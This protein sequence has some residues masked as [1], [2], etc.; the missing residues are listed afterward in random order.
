M[1][2]RP[3]GSQWHEATS[4]LRTRRYSPYNGKRRTHD[5][6]R[7]VI[8]RGSVLRFTLPRPLTGEEQN[9]LSW[10]GLYNEAGLGRLAVNPAMLAGVHPAFEEGTTPAGA[11]ETTAP[12]EPASAL[13]DLLKRRAN[14]AST[15][16]I[17]ATL[18]K[19]LE[20]AFNNALLRARHFHTLQTGEPLDDAPG[21]SQ[22]GQIRELANQNRSNPAKLYGALFEGE[23]ALIRQ[24]SGWQLLLAPDQRLCDEIPDWMITDPAASNA[25][26]ADKN[27][28]SLK[29]LKTHP[30]LPD[31]IGQ[32]ATR[33]LEG[34][35]GQI[36]AGTDTR[37]EE[38]THD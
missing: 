19:D 15:R 1:F 36:I 31:I 13:I 2:N 38:L 9:N 28:V 7:Q 16:Q 14:Q 18:A 32:W 24:R 3:E 30:L 33:L 17:T 22:W 10:A 35:T 4:F 25:S 27:R 37:K 20:S 34:K 29:N 12:A 21:R 5:D 6:E 11:A 8:A 23:N 26:T